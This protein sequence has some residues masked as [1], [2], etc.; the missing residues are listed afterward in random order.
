MNDDFILCYQ[1]ET[2]LLLN[3]SVVSLFALYSIIAMNCIAAVWGSH[4]APRETPWPHVF[5]CFGQEYR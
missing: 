1:Q 5:L 4:S 2:G 3:E